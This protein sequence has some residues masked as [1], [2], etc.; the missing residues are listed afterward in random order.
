MLVIELAKAVA[1]VEVG[2]EV[3]VLSDDPGAN[4]GCRLSAAPTSSSCGTT[5][6]WRRSGP[7]NS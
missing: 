4:I 2:E 7:T 3:L 1:A 6:A 5:G